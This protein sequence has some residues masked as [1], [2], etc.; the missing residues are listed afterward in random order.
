MMRGPPGLPVTMQQ[1]GRPRSTI[2][3]VMLESGRLPGA[4]ALAPRTSTRPKA[5]GRLG[6]TEKSS[7]SS[8]STMPVPGTVMPE[9]KSRLTVCVSATALPAASV[10][11]RCVVP[12]VVRA[13]E[14]RAR[15]LDRD[16]VAAPGPGRARATTAGRCARAARAA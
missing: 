14:A 5:L 16:L 7:I 9:P 2:V 8:F 4:T 15:H 11:E 1:L 12:G 13:A 3:G 10:T 6:A